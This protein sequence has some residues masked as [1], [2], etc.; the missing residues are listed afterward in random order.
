MSEHPFTFIVFFYAAAFAANYYFKWWLATK[1]PSAYESLKR[2][3]DDRNR[4]MANAAV[5]SAQAGF[6][7]Y[8]FFR[9]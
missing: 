7:L 3:E 1:H 2:I 9:R 5:K 4:R 8:R 6:Q